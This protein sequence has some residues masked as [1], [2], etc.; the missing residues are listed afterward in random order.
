[1]LRLLHNCLKKRRYR[2]NRGNLIWRQEKFS[3]LP[4]VFNFKVCICLRSFMQ[5]KIIFRPKK[6][7]NNNII[8]LQSGIG[9]KKK[10]MHVGSKI[11]RDSTRRLSRVDASFA[12]RKN[13]K[14]SQSC[15]SISSSFFSSTNAS[16]IWL[17]L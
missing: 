16:Q 6:N 12:S 10:K 5:L 9:E 3:L 15:E 13:V 4:G 7:N 14:N 17:I 11:A 2:I 8:L 1:M